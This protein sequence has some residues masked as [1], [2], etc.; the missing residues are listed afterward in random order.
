MSRELNLLPRQ[1]V[2]NKGN[3]GNSKAIIISL[4]VVLVCVLGSLGI[5]LGSTIYYQSKLENLNL[6]LSNSKGKLAER[7]RLTEQID[8]TNKQIEKAEQLKKIKENDTDGLLKLMK[9]K[10]AVDG[11]QIVSFEYVGDM[12]ENEEHKVEVS[13]IT[14]NHE[15]LQKVWAN[16]RETEEFKQSQINSCVYNDEIL[17]YEYKLTISFEGGNDNGT[18]N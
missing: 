8:I 4:I 1:Q 12:V 15:A 18:E 3:G 14:P 17:A 6:Q 13:G 16:L 11:V 9:D 2:A 5:S 7:D 10:I